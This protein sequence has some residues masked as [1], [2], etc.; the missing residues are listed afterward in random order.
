MEDKMLEAGI[1]Q[2]GPNDRAFQSG[3]FRLPERPGE[4]PRLIG[5]RCR[6]CGLNLYPPK[7]VCPKCWRSD[8]LE[9]VRLGP[10]G[11]LFTYSV[12]RIGTPQYA[13]S[14]PYAVGYVDLAEGVRV[15]AQIALPDFRELAIGLEL[16][17]F[18]DTLYTDEENHNIVGYKFRPKAD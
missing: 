6:A 13:K 18:I 10:Y 14:T 7:A 17:L 8:Q 11:R 12:V 3:L 5:T 2:L 1:V 16:E 4:K 9:E 15:F